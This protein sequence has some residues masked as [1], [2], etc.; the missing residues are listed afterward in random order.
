MNQQDNRNSQ[1][2]NLDENAHVV[3][4]ACLQFCTR[5]T[6]RVIAVNKVCMISTADISI[7]SGDKNHLIL[8]MHT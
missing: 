7:L 8:V 4:E 2:I 6:M 1:E 3:Q 5:E